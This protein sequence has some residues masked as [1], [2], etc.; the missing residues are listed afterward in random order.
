VSRRPPAIQGS[1][2]RDLFAAVVTAALVGLLVAGW[3]NQEIVDLGGTLVVSVVAAAGMVAYSAPAGVAA[4]LLRTPVVTWIGTRAYALIVWHWP[5]LLVTRPDGWFPWEGAFGTSIRLL[6]VVAAAGL[7]YR[8]VERPMAQG[9]IG[10]AFDQLRRAHGPDFLRLRR[11]LHGTLGAITVSAG[12]ITVGMLLTPSGAA[13]EDDVAPVAEQEPAPVDCAST[14]CAALTFDDGPGAPTDDLLEILADKDVAATFFMLGTQIAARP[15]VARSVQ[16]AGHEIGVHTWSHAD[17]VDIGPEAARDQLDRG[18]DAVAE[19]TGHPPTLYRPPYGST[20]SA[21]RQI[22]ADAGLTEILWD[23][24]T[25]DWKHRDPDQT[26]ALALDRTRNGS[27]VLMHDVRP[28]TVEAVPDLIDGLR[29]AGLTLVPVSTLLDGLL[30]PGE[31][32]TSRPVPDPTPA[33]TTPS[34]G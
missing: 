18:L 11:R 25:R 29:A 32:F 4:R 10:A 3:D 30:E 27:I 21:V 2:L 19:L 15:D 5:V 8:L 6:L 34:T 13:T 1:L 26:I 24:D 20:N 17:L 22:A 9:A 33:S 7:S 16:E 23:V 14:A 31:S 28:T 12:V